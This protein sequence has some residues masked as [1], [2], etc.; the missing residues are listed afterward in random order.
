MLTKRAA[1]VWEGKED[2][3]GGGDVCVYVSVCVCVGGGHRR[4]DKRRG[5]PFRQNDVQT[6]SHDMAL[7]NACKARAALTAP[8]QR[9]LL[10]LCPTI[11]QAASSIV[12]A[13]PAQ[14]SSTA[15]AA[16]FA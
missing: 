6:V 4:D 1:R 2:G 5:Q 3:G 11:H 13:L 15:Q 8:Y 14:P 16:F 10:T 9:L 7:A 12:W